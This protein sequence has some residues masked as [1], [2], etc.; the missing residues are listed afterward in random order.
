MVAEGKFREDLYYRLNIMRLKIPPLRERHEDLPEIIQ[1]I[2]HRLNRSG[3]Y[4]RGVTHSA[5]TKLMKHSWPGNVREL[6]NILERAA[7]K[8]LT[9]SST[10]SSI[11]E[12][13]NKVGIPAPQASSSISSTMILVF[14]CSCP[15]DVSCSCHFPVGS[16]PFAAFLLVNLQ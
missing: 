3:F 10:F 5:L 14:S 8:C 13:N 11:D 12:T 15:F 7:K 6:K 9:P 2:I 4:I 16:I 1:A